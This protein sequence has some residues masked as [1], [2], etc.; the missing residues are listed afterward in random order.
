MNHHYRRLV[1]CG[2]DNAAA[3]NTPM[4]LS[5][6]IDFL[7]EPGE[8]HVGAESILHVW[9]RT[10]KSNTDYRALWDIAGITTHNVFPIHYPHIADCDLPM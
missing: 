10:R 2:K 4:F 8:D 3:L 7:S 5:G 6:R 9:I 1:E